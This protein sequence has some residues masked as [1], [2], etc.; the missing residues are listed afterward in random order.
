MK[1]ILPVIQ[2]HDTIAQ[3]Q[4]GTGKTGTFS[5]ATLQTID[6]ASSNLQALIV[7]PTRELSLQTA[8]VINQ[9]GEYMG[10]KVHLCVGGTQ[11]RDDIKALK[12]GGVH[13]VVGTPGRINDMIRKEV[14]KTDYIRIFV[15]DEADEMLDKGF[16]PQMQEIFKVMP[17]DA[18]IALFS[19][20]MPEEMLSLTKHFMKDPK[21][22]LV[23]SQQLSLEGISQYY[24]AVD[25]ENWKLDVLLDL[26]GNLDI[27]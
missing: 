26:Y 17:G 1:G 20:T 24:I 19:A 22:I 12:Y 4:S 21:K 10:I 18:Q 15:M 3:A 27:N 23:K 25:Q 16:K 8:F 5:I 7:S 9:I 11:I 14:L 13:V 2:G 6:T